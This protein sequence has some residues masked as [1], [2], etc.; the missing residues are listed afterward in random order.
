MT[1]ARI[2]HIAALLPLLSLSTACATA[3]SAPRAQPLPG[4]APHAAAV[5]APGY[6]PHRVYDV[7]AGTFI[8]FETFA[9][10]AAAVDV[11]LF[12]EQHGHGPTHR[13]Q[14]ALLEGLDRRGDAAVSMEMFERDVAHILAGY[15][16][17]QV[18]H[19]T[20]LAH[21][22]PWSNYFPDYHPLV[23]RARASG[24]PAIGANVPRALANRVA[25]EGIA[26][27]DAL[28][29]SARGHVA[30]ELH[31]PAD[32]YRA[33]FFTEMRR[34]P[35]GPPDETPESEEARL[36]RYYEAQCVKDETMAEAIVAAVA[37]GRP[38]VHFTGAF[39]SDYGDGIG[40]RLLRR[41]P[42]VRMLS[43]TTVP[44]A[45]LDD[46]DPAD[47][48]QRADYLLFTLTVLRSQ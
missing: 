4:T 6:T 2:A 47:H 20:F 27:I 14:L 41:M 45:N 1:P 31:C 48:L 35:S 29:A 40:A 11:V 36:Q 44:V 26:T 23:E 39:H 12:G 18:S 8:D 46:A 21:T 17:N 5:P 9:A 43:I 22:R 42:G 15:V 30:A 38:V 37:E 34:H 28:D 7:A 16:A 19:E 10:R 33:R 25:R 32:E 13:M 24:W 3:S